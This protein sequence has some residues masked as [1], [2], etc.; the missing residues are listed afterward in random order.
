MKQFRKAL[1]M[2]LSV[3]MLC[4]VLPLSAMMVSAADNLIVNGDFENGATSWVLTNDDDTATE[5]IDDPTGSGRGKVMHAVSTYNNSN[6]RDDMFYQQPSMEANTDYVLSFKVYCYST[7]SNAAFIVNFYDKDGGQKVTYNTSDVTGLACQN[8]DSSSAVRVRLNVNSNTGKWV[9]VS[10]PFN[11]G[12]A[13]TSR[14]LFANYRVQQGYYY[15]DDVVLTKVGGDEPETPVEPEEPLEPAPADYNMLQN[16]DFEL[17]DANWTALVSNAT[18]VNDPTGTG[19]GKVMQTNESG[20]GVGMFKQGV[21][22]SANTDYILKFKVYTYAASGTKPGFWATVGTNTAAYNSSGVVCYPM[23]HKSVNNG[24]VRFTSVLDAAYNAWIDVTVPFNSGS[25][26]STNIIL[27]NYRADAGQYYFD[28]IVLVRADGMMEPGEDEPETPDTP[29]NPDAPVVTG[30]LVN[31]GNFETGDTTGWKPN[32][33]TTVNTEAAKTG[34]YGAYLSGKGSY[35]SLLNTTVDVVIGKSYVVNMWLKVKAVGVNV[36]VKADNDS[37]ASLAG[38]WCSASNYADWTQISFVVSPTTNAL[39]INICGAGN[40]EYEIAYIDDVSVTEAPLI[41][42][43]DFE[44]G[45][46]S[47]WE[48][49]QSTTISANAAYEGAYGVNIKGNGSWGGMLNQNMAVKS[50]KTYELTFWYKINANGFTLQ[51]QGVQ[52]GTMYQNKSIKSPTGTWTQYT[53]TVTSNGDSAI[54]LNFSGIGG[55]GSANASL[56]E[57]AYIDSISLVEQKSASN[58]GYILNGD[59]EYKDYTTH[60]SNVNNACTAT[61][62]EG[63]NG[64][65]ALSFTAPKWCQMR[66]KFA[67]DANTDYTITLW[68]KDT[69]AITLLLKTGATDE[70]YAQKSISAGSTWTEITYDFNSGNNTSLYLG[71]MGQD[72]G[73]G[74]AVIDDIVIV[75]NKEPSFDGY[76]YNGDFESGKLGKWQKNSASLSAL[77]NDAH[78]G[79]YAASVKGVGDWG[80]HLLYQE[81][82]LEAGKTYTLSFWYKPLS[83]GV[84]YTLRTPDKSATF[85]TLYLDSKKYADWTYHEVT[86]EAGTATLV[87]LTFS[88]SG[89]NNGV[90][91]EVLVDDFRLVNLSGN[92]MDRAQLMTD[93]GAS[94]RDTEDGKPAL[95][96][97]FFLSANGIQV[98]KGNQ[99]V[100]NTGSLKL[101]KYAEVMGNL[102]KFGAIVTNN[103]AIGTDADAFTLENINGSNFIDVNAKYLMELDDTSA[104]YAVRI[105]NIPNANVGNEIYVRPYYLYE[106]DGETYTIYGDITNDNYAQVESTRRTKRVLTLGGNYE[107]INDNLYDVLKSAEYDQVILGN[108]EG[109]TYYKNDDNGKWTTTTGIDATTAINDER[110]QYIVVTN[111]ADL[112]WAEANKPADAKILYNVG[113]ENFA[114]DAAAAESADVDGIIGSGTALE[115]LATIDVTGLY[116]GDALS[117]KGDYVVSLTWFV[118]LTGESL[119]LVEWDATYTENEEY[120]LRRAAARAKNLPCAVSDLSETL[121]VAGSDFQPATNAQGIETL[122]SLTGSL[123]NNGYSSFDGML[124]V[125]DYTREH[126]S[127]LEPGEEGRNVLETEMTNYVNFGHVYS[128]GNHD[129]KDIAGMDNYG[130]N[131]PKGGNYGVFVIN[132]DNYD[133]YGNGGQ[134]VATDLI[135]YFAEKKAAGWGNQPIFVMSHLPLHY[136]YRTMKDGGAKTA[137]YIINALNTASEDG[138]NIIFLIGHNHSGGYDDSLGGAAIYIPKGDSIPVPD[139]TN[140]KNAPIEMELKFTYMNAGYVSYYNDMG[141]GADCSLT[142]SAFRIQ[143]NGDVIITRYDKNGVHNLKSAGKLSPYDRDYTEYTVADGR[144]YESSRIVGAFKDEEYED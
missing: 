19:K 107:D 13:V 46:L 138:F 47:G 55:S 125:G 95:A 121:L 86:F 108:L 52:S 58:D 83:N 102:K 122:R 3:L 89:K 118:A 126:G 16:G 63:H 127:V 50:G 133:A 2:L 35:G 25:E 141:M 26:T 114:A 74:A 116:E 90:N 34:S 93:G 59:F 15:F 110:W 123:K 106:L 100:Q 28:D 129:H 29:A 88:G 51:L 136:N 143:A 64:G 66:Q 22:I 79:I 42:N 37:G 44:T 69:T 144:V 117:D 139:A 23:E 45:D 27:S 38:K 57:D 97:R 14:I 60:W 36:Q 40:G 9:D 115:S 20:S 135:N 81:I 120:N 7:A 82:N 140:I 12:S 67:V 137:S 134:T 68:A 124:F 94:I 61:L 92:E 132:E 75:A 18:V 65:Q 131:D 91:D 77:S 31:N 71:F 24:C 142:M 41:S 72:S 112:A 6:G 98:E 4:S 56:A 49:W 87:E 96:F 130:N 109:D 78:D 70:N 43:G 99:Y 104:S 11:S 17:G 85:D 101:Y 73:N 119:D 1:A 32:Q 105:L 103:A 128:Q 30:N 39:F 21:S 8:I 54:K 76:I 33:S 53:T 80:G 111:D 84:N 10:I 113:Y 62:V 48:K 5:V